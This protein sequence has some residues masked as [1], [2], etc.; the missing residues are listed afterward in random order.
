MNLNP[1]PRLHGQAPDSGGIPIKLSITAFAMIACTFGENNHAEA[2][3]TRSDTPG[4]TSARSMRRSQL[5]REV[6]RQAQRLA[7]P[8]PRP[9]A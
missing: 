9:H 7:G 4:H 1:E 2:A 5:G 6:K 3:F 8:Q